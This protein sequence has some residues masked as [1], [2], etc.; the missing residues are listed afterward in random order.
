MPSDDPTGFACDDE[1]Q[2]TSIKGGGNSYRSDFTYDGKMRLRRRIDYTYSAGTWVVAGE[3]RYIYDGMV[4]VQERN[5]SNV[6]TVSYTR[7]NDLSGS[8]QGAGGIGGLLARSSGYNT[9]TGAWST[10]YFYHA[11]GNGNVTYLV[12]PAGVLGATYK[13]DPFGN[14]ISSSGSISS[15]NVYRF[16]SK[17]MHSGSGMYYYGYR[18]YNPDLQRWMNQDPIQERGGI[19]LYRYNG[20]NSISVVDAW[21]LLD[22]GFGKVVPEAVV[23]ISDGAVGAGAVGV[24]AIGAGVVIIV[25]AITHPPNPMRG[26]VPAHPGGSRRNAP[27]N[28]CFS[29]VIPPL[30]TATPVQVAPY[31]PSGPKSPDWGPT[32]RET[33][34]YVGRTKLG[35]C[36]YQCAHGPVIKDPD[37]DGKCDD[38]ITRY[39]KWDDPYAKQ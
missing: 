33:C 25:V 1:N 14:T 18:W 15:A 31:R 21:G 34:Y 10:Q 32:G 19:N 22:P 35:K 23:I 29:G 9:S 12:S 38:S 17:E 30:K 20:N 4:V 6:P 11:D 16:S 39:Y 8:L 24:G 3:T 27:P 37:E 5:S 36:V 7:G 2:L 13:Y 26:Y 28:F